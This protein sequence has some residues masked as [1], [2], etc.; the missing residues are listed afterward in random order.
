MP[1]VRLQSSRSSNSRVHLR[2]PVPSYAGAALLVVAWLWVLPSDALAAGRISR[3]AVTARTP[4]A[5]TDTI[6][7]GDTFSTTVSATCYDGDGNPLADSVTLTV[8]G[9][10]DTGGALAAFVP[11]P[12]A[13][14]SESTLSVVTS[15]QTD[16]KIYTLSI[17]GTGPVCGQYSTL[18]LPLTVLPVLDL[19]RQDLMT[20]VATGSPAPGGSFAYDTAV[21]A[22]TTVATLTMASGVEATT[23]PNTT[24]LSD[25]ANPSGSGAPSPGGLD[26]YTV[27]YTVAG[28]RATNDEGN[29]FMVP[30]FGMSCYYTT[31][32][33]DWGSP[34]DRCRR[35]R[36]K[37]TVYS[38][39]VTDPYGYSGT[40]C[41]SFIA[42][43]KLQGSGVTNG[44]ASIQYDPATNLITEVASITGA[45][46]TAVLADHTVARDRRVISGRGVLVDVHGIGTG[47]LAN[48][49]GND[50]RGYRLD[51]YRGAGA[52]VCADY[53]NPMGVAACQ[54]AQS[55]CPAKDLQ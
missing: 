43:V 30:V 6:N 47:L 38:G 24:V 17:T 16:A 3:L 20:V 9:A 13:T 53:D 55:R 7:A 32:E 29:P 4:A 23:N 50:I 11:N 10:P 44:G 19:S 22:G 37:G 27:N 42:E 35:V 41:S 14:F 5:A 49:T 39:T 52:G 48:D 40:F 51:L 28:L 25:P 45:D 8:T 34:P 12:V 26:K 15:K 21:T 54:P 18:T 1:E 36:I 46:G 33:S 2:V 31:L